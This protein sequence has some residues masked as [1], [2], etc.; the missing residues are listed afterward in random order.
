[1]YFFCFIEPST[2]VYVFVAYIPYTT[3][4]DS[5]STTIITSFRPAAARFLQ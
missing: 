4:P 3:P 2:S 5:G 1:M